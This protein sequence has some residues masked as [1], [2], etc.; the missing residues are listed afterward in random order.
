MKTK[1]VEFGA[2]DPEASAGCHAETS[3]RR[4]RITAHLPV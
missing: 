4:V 1:N 2:F 3:A